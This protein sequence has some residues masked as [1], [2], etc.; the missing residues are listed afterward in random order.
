MAVLASS[1]L[2]LHA[3]SSRSNGGG[4]SLPTPSPTASATPTPTT[5][6]SPT[7]T[8]TATLFNAWYLWSSNAQ[9]Q[10]NTG[11][12]IAVQGPYNAFS[13]GDYPNIE[14]GSASTFRK[15]DGTLWGTGSNGSG[16]LG[17]NDISNRSSI[18]Q[19][20]TNVV[21]NS[22]NAAFTNFIKSDGTLWSSGNNTAGQLGINVATNRSSPVQ[23]IS[24]K[25]DWVKCVA[26]G[27]AAF[28]IDSSGRLYGSGFNTNGNLGIN[29]ATNRSQ[30]TQ[31]G[32]DNTWSEISCGNNFALSIKTDGSLWGWGANTLGQIGVNTA[33]NISSPVQIAIGSTW[34]KVAGAGSATIALKSDNTVWG[35]GNAVNGQLGIP[36]SFY[37]AISSPIQI[38]TGTWLDIDI[39]TSAAFAINTNNEL[40]GSGLTSASS[41]NLF[42]YP[43]QSS[44]I[45]LDNVRQWLS[46]SQVKGQNNNSM[47]AKALG[48]VAGTPTPTPSPTNSPTPTPT[49]APSSNIV[50]MSGSA[51]LEAYG[52]NNGDFF[53]V[54]TPVGTDVASTFRFVVWNAAL[55]EWLCTTDSGKFYYSTDGQNW[56]LATTITG[57]VNGMAFGY[58]SAGTPMVVFTV[59][60][61]IGD[62]RFG[63]TYDNRN[64]TVS[65]QTNPDAVYGVNYAGGNFVSNSIIAGEGVYNSCDG[66]NWTEV[67]TV[68][69]AEVY[70][71]AY[72]PT[73]NR[74]VGCVGTG[75]VDVTNKAIYSDNYGATWTDAT[76]PQTAPYRTCV[77]TGSKFAAINAYTGFIALSNDGITWTLGGLMSG[78]GNNLHKMCYY[79][80]ALYVMGLGY[81]IM[82]KSADQGATWSQINLGTSSSWNAISG[83][84][85]LPTPNAPTCPPS[86]SPSPSPTL[87]PSPTP[88]VTESPTPT[89]SPTSTPT[90]SASASPT[91]TPSPSATCTPAPL[92]VTSGLVAQF[93]ASDTN[94]INTGAPS[95]GAQ[96]S[97]WGNSI[98]NATFAGMQQA[99]SVKQPTWFSDGTIAGTYVLFDNTATTNGDGMTT[100]GAYSIGASTPFTIVV[101]EDCGTQGPGTQHRTIQSSTI[102]ALISLNQ[103]GIP[104]SQIA[105]YYASGIVSN[106][107]SGTGKH[108]GI[109]TR[110]AA[111]SIKY[112]VDGTDRTSAPFTNSTAFS[113]LCFGAAGASPTEPANT[114]LLEVLVYNRELSAAEVVQV[115]DYLLCKWTNPGP[116]PQPSTTPPSTPTPTPT[117][118]LVQLWAW[119][120]NTNGEY[121]NNTAGAT[122]NRSTP[123]FIAANDW[124]VIPSGG[125]ALSGIRQ[126]GTLYMW[127]LNSSGELGQNNIINR[128]T[129][130]QVGSANNWSWVM[131][132]RFTMA[133]KTDGS[134]WS[135]GNNSSGQLGLNNTINLSSPVQVGADTTW[136]KVYV[137]RFFT[138]NAYDVVF[139]IKTNGSLWGWGNNSAGQL[140]LVDTVNRSSPVQVGLDTNWSSVAISGQRFALAIKTDGTLWSVGINTNGSLGINNAINRSSFTQVGTD[141][142]WTQVSADYWPVGGIKSNG[143]LWTWGQNTNGSLGA[144]IGSAFNRSSP[145][146]VGAENTWAQIECGYASM[147]GRKTDGTIWAWGTA[148]AGQLGNNQ[149]QN[150]S[151]PVLVSGGYVWLSCSANNRT[152]LGVLTIAPTPTPA[153]T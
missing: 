111:N 78:A 99:T 54:L 126:D 106:Y 86:P 98:T 3:G 89:E 149:T 117:L 28:A 50:G 69:Y 80:G 61:S 33:V 129:P 29:T 77:W 143:T 153:P 17:Q 8:P 60:I 10:L 53:A 132:D 52:Q 24:G 55:N 15:F 56:T 82:W 27:S 4:G 142:T 40:W 114:K 5:T 66:V 1:L 120:D 87:T 123:I 147:M 122:T 125:D 34:L 102:N 58:N 7:P 65:T 81:S 107:Q 104:P 131:N 93:D 101:M 42:T 21:Y 150:Q 44:F 140:G 84:E 38:L 83:Q 137:S 13:A 108:N 138:S 2:L 91:P 115:S 43:S 26:G 75:G 46:F 19:I 92:P 9:G 88:S 20:A 57:F 48:P 32:T 105:A 64:F 68:P 113:Q 145:A 135:W 22:A 133:I 146:Q 134:L 128:S 90:P 70:N 62:Y 73:N 31:I 41:P 37:P 14:S 118:P 152:S 94:K 121:S 136:S 35:W 11:N 67:G 72:N 51:N 97:S 144:N 109:L 127:G 85:P 151:S 30:F 119:G 45:M 148:S 103:Y 12:T 39:N 124:A 23:E 95:N 110:S 79:N 112:Y 16:A 36:D 130:T 63:Y 74:L 76:L 141:N 49:I 18:V 100:N 139:A 96:V 59:Q 71:L 25:T 116:T 6:A 47:N